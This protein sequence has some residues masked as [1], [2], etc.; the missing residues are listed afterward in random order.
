MYFAFGDSAI[1]GQLGGKMKKTLVAKRANKNSQQ[2]QNP[3]IKAVML[4]IALL[5]L[6]SLAQLNPYHYWT[7]DHIT[8]P[9][10]DS[11]GNCA[12][13]PA[14]YNCVYTLNPTGAGSVGRSLGLEV[15]NS[16]AIVATNNFIP[17]STLTIEFLFKSAGGFN[18][19]E[20]VRRRDN[21]INIRIGYPFIQFTTN[22]MVNG[23]ISNDQFKIELEGVGRGSYGYYSDGNWH[24][25]V[26]KYNGTTGTKE[27][28]VDGQLPVGFSKAVAKGI[29]SANT[30]N[31][32]NNIIDINSNTSYNKLS[33]SL[34]EIAF[35]KGDLTPGNIYKHFT[36][37]KSGLHYTFNAT[38]MLPPTPSPVTTGIDPAEYAPG[39][40]AYSVSAINQLK[41]FPLPRYKPAN[42]LP[43]N[44]N[45]IGLDYFSG[46][47]QPG[48]ST[49]TAVTNSVNI[50]KELAGNWNYYVLVSGNTSSH[51]SYTDPTKFHG[52]W[53]Q[54][55]NQNPQWGASAISFWNQLNPQAAGFASNTGYIENKTL[56]SN[57]YLRNSSGQFLSTSGSVT[58]SKF[59]SPAAPVDSIIL[60]GRTQRFYLNKLVNALT[61]PLDIISENGE[62]IPKFN[63]TAMALDPTVTAK[64]NA[65]GLDWDTYQ[66]AEKLRLASSYRNEFMNTIPQ[67]ANTIFGEYQI[68]GHN[69]RHKYS[70][71]RNIQSLRNGQRYATPDFYPRWP[72]NW[73]TGTGPWNGWQ[74]IIDGR[75]SELAEGDKLFSPYIAA[76]W[77]GDEERNIRPAQWLGLMKALAGLGAE[78]YYTGYFNE[79]SS[80]NPPNPAPSNPA[81]YAW[82]AVVPTYAQAITSRWEDLLRNGTLLNGDMSNNYS[83]PTG[84]GYTF[85]C[86]DLRKL[87]VIR[88]AN[89]ANRYVICST[90]QPNSNMQGNAEMEGDAKIS[91]NGQSLQFKVR[92]QGSTYIY[93]NSNP[94]APV[95]YQLDGWHESSHPYNWSKDFNFEAELYDNT[96]AN[97][98]IATTVPV[99]T[100]AGDFR[101][102]TTAVQVTNASAAM[103]TFEY[104]FTPRN[105][106]TYYVWVK[107]RSRNGVSS[108]LNIGLSGQNMKT[109][110]CITDTTWKWYSL[111]SCTGNAI[112]F[113][114][115]N[116]Q[117]YRLNIIPT[118]AA[119]EIDQVL[120]TIDPFINLNANQGS[121][122]ASIV[123]VT[124]N[125]PLAI[126]PGKSVSLTAPTANSYTWSNGQTTQSIVVTN[127]GNYSVSVNQG[128]A[129]NSVSQIVAVTSL[130][131]PSISV[132]GNLMFCPGQNTTLTAS[133]ASNYSW[134]TGLNAPSITINQSGTYTVTANDAN[135]CSAN[136]TVSVSTYAPVNPTITYSTNDLSVNPSIKLTANGGTSYSWIPGGSTGNTLTVTT[137]GT[138]SVIATSANGCTGTS[139]PVT[140]LQN[141]SV[142]IQSTGALQFCKGGSVTLTASGQAQQILWSPGGATTASI[143]ATQSGTYYAYAMDGNGNIRATDS[144]KVN[145]FPTPMQPLLSTTYVPGTAYQILAS[146]PSAVLY[147]WGNGA[148]TAMMT[149]TAATSTTVF[150]KN[151]FGCSSA[152]TA[153]QVAN[154][155]V[156]GCGTPN[157][158]VYSNPSD[159]SVIVQWNPAIQAQQF[160]IR[161]NAIGS[162]LVN[163]VIVAGNI[164]NT[165]IGGLT[166]GTAY[167]WT[168]EA[169][170]S[171]GPATS[172]TASFTTLIGQLS[173][174]SQPMHTNATAITPR[175]ANLNWY[176]TEADSFQ[177]RFRA[178]G[179]ANYRNLTLPG[180]S[181][182]GTS[183]SGLT[184]AT[185][186]EWQIRS[187]CAGYISAFT[188]QGYFSTPDTCGF[189]G[190][191]TSVEIRSNSVTL[192]WGNTT[193][194]DSI[195]IRIINVVTGARR[196][197]KLNYNPST[198]TYRIN[199]LQANTQYYA[200]LRGTCSN[201]IAGAWTTP[202]Y[203][204]TMATALREDQT[205]QLNAYPNPAS[206]LLTYSFQS[207]SDEPYT[208][209]VCDMSG[210]Q[211]L[212]EI[213]P[214]EIGIYT[215]EIPVN[216]Y[217]KGVYLL[218]ITQGTMTGHF[219]FS[220][221]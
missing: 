10:R 69:T 60:D 167:N 116:N 96:P 19:T 170:C 163:E 97:S 195:R 132:S 25:L 79:A 103:P 215:N 217:A 70:Q 123:N 129:C 45:W 46:F 113:T 153:V 137:P 145:V 6:S 211:L 107:V 100:S 179:A 205:L 71:T 141:Y 85:N 186:Y 1:K 68:S 111:E 22:V 98:R 133:G 26:F 172:A 122:G 198:G 118:N 15:S 104:R 135:G 92:R 114:G 150:V 188:P 72:S 140:I 162:S 112:S 91:L 58:T 77:N 187:F 127:P 89:S 139:Q 190:N 124:A 173:C 177:V 106:P 159:T 128:G 37:F 185:T 36:E 44:F 147:Q 42:T 220:V 134:S 126:C 180:N 204:T 213:R 142:S 20:F 121:C 28:W 119:L 5:P 200:E 35:Y 90:L 51:S 9:M 81:G 43:K 208:V 93:D 166:A 115:M 82:Q 196:T 21:A 136:S 27:I 209:R 160:T 39:H 216:T 182:N 101:N 53:V 33:G 221:Q 169:L 63:S 64:K 146:E 199:G 75:A 171:S 156:T 155:T 23:T 48:T 94:A 4:L 73:L 144:I 194:M 125:G 49:A 184:P 7:F 191:V 161:Y 110:G 84:P 108:G 120:L 13:N 74:H 214:S 16:R 17:D 59:F 56:T 131:S 50:Q 212:Q 207:E 65:S 18:L 99:N 32:N 174:G 83:S 105:Q 201:G 95:F 12:L 219:R 149:F 192:Q 109:I 193:P 11:M 54:L 157:M 218:I 183:L 203:F 117:E 138:Y 29:F 57:H 80:Y 152:A 52:A 30:T 210:R 176:A 189:L 78:F 206:D 34:D 66:G 148:T 151:A 175:R 143:Q 8:S 14:Y 38:G 47:M 178:I 154:P 181:V 24:H 3:L 87:V 165:R 40:P 2:K 88:K 164:N 158:L 67:L 61:R 197:V 202:F 55:A 130:G 86:G 62:V 41:N 31:P 76:G 102:Y 168:V